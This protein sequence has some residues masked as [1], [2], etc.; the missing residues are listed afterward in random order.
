[1]TIRRRALGAD[2][3]NGEGMTS[4]EW[5]QREGPTSLT[6]LIVSLLSKHEGHK[7]IATHRP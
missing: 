1:M 5:R 7:A 3:P 2:V 4:V 6:N